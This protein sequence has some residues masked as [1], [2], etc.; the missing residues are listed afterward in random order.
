VAEVDLER[1]AELREREV[2]YV[3]RLEHDRRAALEVVGDAFHVCRPGE[4]GRA[5]RHSG[6]V[7]RD[8]DLLAFL[9]DANSRV[10]Q[11]GRGDEALGLG[12]REQVVEPALLVARDD[13]RPAL[14]V[15]IEEPVGV[16]RGDAAR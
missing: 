11:A 10:A 2:M 16:D 13:E 4:A 8:R 15:R 14:P 9:D 3:E 5:P 7:R 6:R 1:A 12:L